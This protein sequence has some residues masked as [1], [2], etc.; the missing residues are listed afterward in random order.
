MIIIN[1]TRE[2]AIVVLKF[3]TTINLYKQTWINNVRHLDIESPEYLSAVI[4]NSLLGEVE[5]YIENKLDRTVGKFQKFEFTP[6]QAA[7]FHKALMS[8]PIGSENLYL[9]IIRNNWANFLW[10]QLLRAGFYQFAENLS[11]T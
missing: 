5:Q 9:Q 7:V 1:S 10:T 4:I 6:A 2:D 8:M 11:C 3:F